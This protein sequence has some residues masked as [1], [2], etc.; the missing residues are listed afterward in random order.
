MVAPVPIGEG[1]IDS[2]I[3]SLRE[4]A[5]SEAA[6]ES[7]RVTA[8]LKIG[9]L[10]FEDGRFEEAVPEYRKL[11]EDFPQSERA[12]LGYYQAAVSAYKHGDAL[13][14]EDENFGTPWFRW[15]PTSLPPS[16]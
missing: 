15:Q 5:A 6:D 9:N 12:A 7:A 16:L 3:A 4:V 10:L 8:Q 2:M 1:G 14:Q 11:A 13:A